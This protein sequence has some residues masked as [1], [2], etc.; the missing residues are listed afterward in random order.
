MAY[1][2]ADEI[3]NITEKN[4]LVISGN[5]LVNV[6]ADRPAPPNLTN[7]ARYHYPETTLNDI[8]YWLERNE[9]KIIVLYYHLYEIEGLQDYLNT[10]REWYL[11]EKIKGK[12]QVLFYGISM[13][14]SRDVYEIY[15]KT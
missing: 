11:Y 12:G 7:L 14:F 1:N 5:P 9:T 15:V 8:I 10:S 3:E 13:K 2:V 4:D 6:I